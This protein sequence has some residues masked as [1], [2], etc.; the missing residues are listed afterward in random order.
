VREAHSP[1]ERSTHAS[2]SPRRWAALL[3]LCGGPVLVV[4]DT[5]MISLA[6]PSIGRG[7]SAGTAAL[8]T[9]VDAYVIAFAGLMVSIGSLADRWGRR[10]MVISGLMVMS[11]ASVGAT[12]GLSIWWVAFMRAV[13]GM[14][15]AMVVPATVALLM[16]EFPARERP[17]AF[18]VWA[19]VAAVALT[20]GPL[21][22]G[23]LVSLFGWRGVFWVNVPVAVVAAVAT[24]RHVR[25]SAAD[26]YPPS[27]L[28]AG[29]LL[30]AGLGAGLVALVAAGR[31]AGGQ[32]ALGVGLVGIAALVGFLWRNVRSA[33]ATIDFVLYR[34]PAFW[35]GSVAA[36]IAAFAASATLFS[37]GQYLQLILGRSAL[38]AGAFLAPMALGVVVGSV[39]GARMARRRGGRIGIG[40]GFT[41]ATLG[42]VVL[43]IASIGVMTVALVCIGL[44]LAGGGVGM[45]GPSVT[46]T[47][48][49][50]VPENRVVMGAALNS[51]HQQLGTAAGIAVLGTV[52]HLVFTARLSQDHPMINTD[53]LVSA[54]AQAGTGTRHE[55]AVQA[56]FGVAQAAI[57]ALAAVLC[58]IAA[59]VALRYVPSG[60]GPR[61][62]G[63]NTCLCVGWARRRRSGARAPLRPHKFRCN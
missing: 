21:V 50:A 10:R 8:Q 57:M 39:L 52:E 36:G 25:E 54:L 16:A 56:A 20:V 13:M 30:T 46:T 17:R 18:A 45:A 33:G 7:L 38:G 26:H 4:L 32:Q 41:V 51:T 61:L 2:P 14:G 34:A 12:W 63:Q 27:D 15:A 49:G 53:S 43:T 9:M 62:R 28:L 40:L 55:V 58:L 23:G 11:A 60:D 3:C 24:L 48:L 44:A 29:L 35:A 47:V 42:F 5:T 6:L 31:P 22:G 37:L 1:P 19:A 59:L